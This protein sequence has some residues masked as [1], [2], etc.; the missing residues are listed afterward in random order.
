MGI[1]GTVDSAYKD[2]KVAMAGG[3][4]ATMAT[5]GWIE[6]ESGTLVVCGPIGSSVGVRRP[7]S[8]ARAA[9]IPSM[10]RGRRGRA[11][12]EERH[13]A[14]ACAALCASGRGGGSIEAREERLDGERCGL[15]D[16]RLA[17]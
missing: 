5:A 15:D 3:D 11:M 12:G 6:Q 1:V 17:E 9:K 13:E 2:I 14:Q 8:C 16:A 7:A 4:S 10:Q